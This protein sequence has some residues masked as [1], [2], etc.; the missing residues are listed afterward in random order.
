[1]KILISTGNSYDNVHSKECHGNDS[2]QEKTK[3][4]PKSIQETEDLSFLYEPIMIDFF[5]FPFPQTDNKNAL[6]T[7]WKMENLADLKETRR[8]GKKAEKEERV[9]GEG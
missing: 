8:D 3:R 9:K 7:E 5:F 2:N 4:K 1:M 6:R